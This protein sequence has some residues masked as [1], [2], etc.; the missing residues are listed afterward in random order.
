MRSLGADELDHDLHATLKQ[1]CAMRLVKQTRFERL[2]LKGEESL[3]G[4]TRDLAREQLLRG[5]CRHGRRFVR[6]GSEFEAVARSEKVDTRREVKAEG[7]EDR[8]EAV[9]RKAESWAK[10]PLAF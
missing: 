8:S 9:E 4:R 1:A 2:A 7:G 6:Y 5:R 10:D 3:F